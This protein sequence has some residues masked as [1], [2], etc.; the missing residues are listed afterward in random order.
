MVRGIHLP[1]KAKTR[2]REEKFKFL[3][4]RISIL[5]KS[6][7]YLDL[8]SLVLLPL[9][10]YYSPIKFLGI[11]PP[12]NLQNKRNGIM[13][14]QWSDRNISHNPLKLSFPKWLCGFCLL[15]YLKR[16]SAPFMISHVHFESSL[17]CDKGNCN[18]WEKRSD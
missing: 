16:F 13:H 12:I 11:V 18:Q 4:E 15:H 17:I 10:L 7:Q 3:I 5:I 14:S 1:M 8:Y 9:D 6:S 2:I